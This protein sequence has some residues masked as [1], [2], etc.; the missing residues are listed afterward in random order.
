[1]QDLEIWVIAGVLA[2]FAAS[3][4]GALLWT[5]VTS[6]INSEGQINPGAF[7]W[8]VTIVAIAILVFVFG[9]QSVHWLYTVVG[10]AI[11]AAILVVIVAGLIRASKRPWLKRR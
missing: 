8:L 7:G 5:L 11:V 6:L 3:V 4:L 1:M 9:E 10:A 2:V